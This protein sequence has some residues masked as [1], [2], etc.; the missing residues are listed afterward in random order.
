MLDLK[1]YNLQ[2]K[3]NVSTISDSFQEISRFNMVRE[4]Y[5]FAKD[6]ETLLAS[7][8]IESI[9]PI[10]FSTYRQMIVRARWIALYWL[11]EQDIIKMFERDFVLSFEI[12]DFDHWEKLLPFLLGMF[13][14]EDRDEFKHK[15]RGALLKNNEQITSA[16]PKTVVGWLTDY[17]VTVGTGIISRIASARYF[18]SNHNFNQLDPADKEK[19]KHLLKFYERIKLSS[20]TIEGMESDIIMTR[21]NGDLIIFRNGVIEKINVPSKTAE[22][23][24]T[25]VPDWVA[26]QVIVPAVVEVVAPVVAVEPKIEVPVV[27]AP[28][29]EVMVENVPVVVSDTAVALPVIVREELASVDVSAEEK[30]LASYMLPKADVEQINNTIFE[31]YSGLDPSRLD[32][33]KLLSDF[34]YQAILDGHKMKVFACLRILAKDNTLLNMLGTDQRFVD[35]VPLR[36]DQTKAQMSDILKFILQGK[37]G[38]SEKEAARWGAEVV[39]A[40]RIHNSSMKSIA[41]WDANTKA[42]KWV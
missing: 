31:I 4:C 12:P 42:F 33:T 22:S 38:L 11:S 10:L 15:I 13:V 18:A 14:F 40:L 26:K 19:I 28:K 37:L 23:K 39:H 3:L 41:E 21:D 27:V 29:Q 20:L 35:L 7:Q 6:L 25:V 2:D 34:F 9:D 17:N 16:E 24:I 30:I 32:F 1:Q 8:K 36:Q 5:G